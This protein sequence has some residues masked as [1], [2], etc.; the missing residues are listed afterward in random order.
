VDVNE[1]TADEDSLEN[2][3]IEEITATS[4]TIATS[5][6]ATNALSVIPSADLKSQPPKFQIIR[7]K[8]R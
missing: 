8:L 5:V 6:P 4:T 1:A 7:I 2:D 3:E